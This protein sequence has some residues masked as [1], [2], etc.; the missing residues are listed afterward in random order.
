[1]FLRNKRFFYVALLVVTASLVAWM[2]LSPSKQS[3]T[4]PSQS[5]TDKDTIAITDQQALLVKIEG[6]HEYEF[7]IQRRAI[8]TVD[9]N[10]EKTVQVFSQY[11]GRIKQVFVTAG[12]IVTLNQP[13][14]SIESP[15]FLQATST[16]ISTAGLRLLA[17]RALERVKKMA[18]IQASSQRD[19]DQ[20]ISDQQTAEGNYRSAR[21]AMRIFG[22]ADQELDFIIS[23]KK[24]SAELIVLSP[25]AGT[26][27][28]RNAQPGLLVQPGSTPA[29]VVVADQ[30]TMWIIANVPETEL[31]FIKEGQELIASITALPGRTYAGKI[32]NIGATVDAATRRIAVRAEILNPDKILRAQML[33]SYVIKIDTSKKSVAIPTES[34]VREGDGTITTFVTSDS[35]TFK[36]RSITIGLTQNNQV[37]VLT[38]LALD[39]KI[40]SDGALF[41]SNAL[42]LQ[43]R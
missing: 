27:T 3:E 4:K 10:Q 13:L 32:V 31:S 33:A 41:L 28:S 36:R 29:P 11:Q 35:R 1:M 14:F 42:A 2:V 12:D 38:G 18:G 40:A 22:K 9:F 37:Q 23:T 8:G 5:R 7:S 39:E 34:M 19:L 20:A 16:L 30:T 15:D 6:T 24:V 43:S 25:I 26:I 17:N 21:D